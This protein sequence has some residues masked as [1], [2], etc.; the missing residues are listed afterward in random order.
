MA[1][2][3]L[4]YWRRFVNKS[5]TR[6]CGEEIFQAE[7]STRPSNPFLLHDRGSRQRRSSR[8]TSSLQ[9]TS[10]H[11]YCRSWCLGLGHTWW[12]AFRCGGRGRL[13]CFRCIHQREVCNQLTQGPRWRLNTA[14][15]TICCSL[16]TAVEPEVNIRR[17][18]SGCG[19]HHCPTS[20][21]R[22]DY[23]IRLWTCSSSGW[24]SGMS[25]WVSVASESVLWKSVV[26]R[27]KTKEL[28]SCQNQ[29]NFL[30]IKQ[31]Q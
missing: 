25:S 3:S 18:E 10:M 11:S 19:W 6:G 16:P 26:L 29:T 4:F 31:L 30:L 13:W 17:S 14:P 23:Q 5:A 2:V 21:H 1:S 24:S 20:S 22:L 8:G 7:D 15:H 12:R 9:G 27:H 28:C